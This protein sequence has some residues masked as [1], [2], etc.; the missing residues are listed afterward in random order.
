M[1]SIIIVIGALGDEGGAA[2]GRADV[3]VREG[4]VLH[5]GSQTRK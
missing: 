2:Q 3:E 5:G 1:I 4:A